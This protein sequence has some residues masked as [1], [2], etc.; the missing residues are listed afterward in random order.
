MLYKMQQPEGRVDVLLECL[1]VCEAERAVSHPV[2]GAQPCSMQVPTAEVRGSALVGYVLFT[3]TYGSS[4][5]LNSR[6]G[7][8]GS[9]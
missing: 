9:T 4:Q 1:F 7:H 6:A 8:D 5:S 3:M 2:E